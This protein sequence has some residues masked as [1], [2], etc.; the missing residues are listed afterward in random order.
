[1]LP[2]LIKVIDERFSTRKEAAEA[3]FPGRKSKESNLS[4]L[5]D[6]DD[7]NK[8]FRRPTM[9]ALGRVFPEYNVNWLLYGIEPKEARRTSTNTV[10]N[11]INQNIDQNQNDHDLMTRI[12]E[13]NNQLEQLKEYKD[14]LLRIIEKQDARIEKQD[15]MIEEMQ[16][17]I[18]NLN[19]QLGGSNHL[20]EERTA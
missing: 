16:A 15:K 2:N 10:Q 7:P 18:K 19:A 9:E 6:S 3:L 11:T 4:S 14:T 17:E 5:L 20:S 12:S 1:M 8:V 13:L